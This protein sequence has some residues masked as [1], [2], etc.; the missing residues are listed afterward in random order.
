MVAQAFPATALSMTRAAAEPLDEEQLLLQ[1][2]RE[3]DLSA[4]NELVTRHERAVY[5]LCRRLLSQTDA[6]EDAVQETFIAAWRNL[7]KL[8]GPIRPW[9]LAVASNFCRSQLRRP[10][11]KRS[12]SLDLALEKG[13][14]EPAEGVWQ[15][16]A[17]AINGALHSAIEDALDRLPSDQRIALTL[18]DIDGFDYGAIAAATRTNVGT[19]KS[20]IARGRLRMRQLLAGERS[21]FVGQPA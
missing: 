13:M 19:V 3:N 17:L 12:S 11:S 8:R 9:L 6:A 1:R 5:L 10:A 18:R 16:E 2:A 14:A 15:P 7:D 20:R 21:E 4:F